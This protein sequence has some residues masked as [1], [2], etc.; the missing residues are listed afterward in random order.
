MEIALLGIVSSVATEV[1]TW[2]NKKWSGTVLQGEGAFIFSAVVSLVIAVFQV[3]SSST[4]PA[5]SWASLAQ[6]G[7]VFSQIWV[8]SQVV[9]LGVVQT[10]KLDVSSTTTTASTTVTK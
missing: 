5:F 9:F 10:L 4:L 7:T 6:F 8:V 3:L 2:L 1:I